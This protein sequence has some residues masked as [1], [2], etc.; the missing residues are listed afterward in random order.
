M[1]YLEV[2]DRALKGPVCKERDFDLK[3]FSKKL[4]D[5]TKEYGIRYDPPNPTPSDNTLAD[6]VFQ[7]AMKFYVEVGTYCLDTGRIIKFKEEEV[8]DALKSAS[9]SIQFGEGRDARVLRSRK[10][11]CANPPWISAGAVGIAVSNEEIFSSLM[12]AYVEYTPLMNSLCTACITSIDGYP[13]R[14]GD[15]SEVEGSMRT[16]MLSKEALRA[17]NRPGLPIVNGVATAVSDRAAI[18]GGSLLGPGDALEIGSIA[19]MKIDFNLMNKIAYAVASNKKIWAGMGP[20]LGGYCG[21]PEGLAVAIVAY[22]FHALL[23]QKATVQ[24][25]YPVHY[26][27]VSNSSRQ[28]LWA[29]SLAYQAIS[30]NTHVPVVGLCYAANGPTVEEGFYEAAATAASNAVSGVS[31]EVQ[32]QAKG[33]GVD[34]LGPLEARLASEV[35]MVTTGMKRK[36]LNEIMRNLLRLYEDKLEKP[37]LGKKYQECFDVR[38]ITPEQNY[39]ETYKRSV[40]KLEEIGIHIASSHACHDS[41]HSESFFD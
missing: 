37:D 17:A 29:V 9:P 33:E 2:T 27:Y 23:V 6:A 36:D 39:L 25:P 3:I 14:L 16:A 26:R 32:G 13:V 4:I 35:A 5:I 15:P 40:K 38:K 11:D 8:K 1:N 19:E 12:R 20:I 30:R 24:H 18:A 28:M 22:N 10:P 41:P 31:I 21:G 7:A 34:H